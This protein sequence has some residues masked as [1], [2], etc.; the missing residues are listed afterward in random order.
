MK[1]KIFDFEHELDL[2]NAINSF[3]D[4]DDIESIFKLLE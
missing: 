4:N 1:V 2:E 3:L